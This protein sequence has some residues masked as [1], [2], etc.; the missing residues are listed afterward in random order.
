MLDDQV[1][2]QI[3][4]NTY[5]LFKGYIRST[6]TPANIPVIKMNSNPKA[7]ATEAKVSATL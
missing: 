6:V 7:F 1:G 2:S 3:D 5:S 4:K